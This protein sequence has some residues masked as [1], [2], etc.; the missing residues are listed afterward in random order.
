MPCLSLHGK[1]KQGSRTNTFF[2]FANADQGTLLCTDV[3]ARGLDIPS[4]DWILQ[5]GMKY[6]FFF[7]K[8]II[9]Y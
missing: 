7:K 6:C 8:K 1:L 9:F 2:E 4:V 3:A 5:F